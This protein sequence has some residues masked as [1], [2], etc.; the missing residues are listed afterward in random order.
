MFCRTRPYWINYKVLKKKINDIVEEQGGLELGIDL[1]RYMLIFK[2]FVVICKTK[3]LLQI[4]IV[5]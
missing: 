4:I 1:R 3:I 5:K 2:F